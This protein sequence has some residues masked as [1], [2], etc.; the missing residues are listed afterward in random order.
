[1]RSCSRR[2]YLEWMQEMCQ[3]SS[4]VMNNDVLL[5][6]LHNQ[7]RARQDFLTRM[8]ERRK[9]EGEREGEKKRK[10]TRSGMIKVCFFKHVQTI[11]LFMLLLTQDI[12][13]PLIY[14]NQFCILSPYCL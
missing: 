9:G 5:V 10:R 4:K 8:L 2:R 7:I 14:Y 6:L 11:M 1:M 12:L 3:H 13:S